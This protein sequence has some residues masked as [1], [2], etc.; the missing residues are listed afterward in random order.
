MDLTQATS[1]LPSSSSYPHCAMTQLALLAYGLAK[2]ND[3]E[4]PGFGYVALRVPKKS[5]NG[6]LKFSSV[7]VKGN[8]KK[9][10]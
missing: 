5:E 8:H 7:P 9:L 3:F 6:D 10:P 2:V 1:L 4:I